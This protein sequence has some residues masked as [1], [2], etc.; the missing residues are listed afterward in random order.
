[1]K[2]GGLFVSVL[3]LLASSAP[4]SGAQLDPPG[5]SLVTSDCSSITIQVQAGDSGAPD[6]F[7][8]EWLPASRYEA[9]GGWPAVDALLGRAE[10]VGIPTLHETPGLDSYRLGSREA[11]LVVLG[12][13]FDETGA[14]ASDAEELAEGTGYVVRARVLPG[15]FDIGAGPGSAALHCRTKPRDPAGCTKSQGYWKNHPESWSRVESV[16]LGRVSY[17]RTQLLAILSKPARGNGLVSLA[18]QLIATRLNLLLGA[19]PPRQV[20]EAMGAAETAIGALV[21][22]PVGTGRLDPA[23]TAPW[24]RALEAFNTG[25]TGPGRCAHGVMPVTTPTWGTLKTIYR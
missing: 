4:A 5:V 2:P 7:V 16:A 11:A 23:A 10:F 17:D 22:P 6:G 1:M 19:V 20:I 13:L 3:L 15:R 21:V 25:A 8:V 18:H 14:V 9:L 12:A 24:T